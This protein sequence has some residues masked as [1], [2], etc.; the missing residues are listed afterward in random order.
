MKEALTYKITEAA[1]FLAQGVKGEKYCFRKDKSEEV[2]VY[3]SEDIEFMGVH[4]V[5]KGKADI[6]AMSECTGVIL[7]L[8]TERFQ[9]YLDHGHLLD[10]ERCFSLT[11]NSR[12]YD[13]VVR[14]KSYRDRIVD[15]L[16]FL[17]EC[18]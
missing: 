18:F 4:V 16:R 12:S 9:Y 14:S 2:V 3:F 15:D 10:E 8:K 6:V 7:G 5:T 13:F 11:F 1:E 17:R